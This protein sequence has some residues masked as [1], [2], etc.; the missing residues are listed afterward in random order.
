MYRGG[1]IHSLVSN[2]A[3]RVAARSTLV[4]LLLAVLL[5][6]AA[7]AAAQG[8]ATTH[9]VAW[10]ETL[11]AI[12]VRY[13]VTTD[14]IM[15]AN[16][17]EAADRIFAGQRLVIPGAGGQATSGAGQTAGQHTVQAGE[18]LFRIGLRYGLSVDELVAANGLADAAQVYAGQTL[19]IPTPGTVSVPS[20]GAPSAGPAVRSHTIQRG[21]TLS[22]ISR[23]YNVSVQDIVNANN[24]VNPSAIFAG[25]TLNI[26][27]AASSGGA[28]GYTPSQAA[29]TY[30]VQRGDSLFSIATRFGV[31]V[32]AITQ[33]NNISNPSL[34]HAGNTLTI[35]APGALTQQAAPQ[36]SAPG[37]AKSIVVDV[38][39]QRAYVYENG[40]LKWTFIISTGMPGTP[41]AR[42]NFQVQNKIPNAYAS[43]WDLQ[44]PWW[45][46]IYWAG[47][48]QNGFHALPIMS[49][50]VRLWAGLLGS[51][52]SYGCIILSEYDAKTLYDWADIG[53]PVTIRD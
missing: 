18:N 10:G 13:G 52:A 50:G 5:L 34:V 33:A 45:L 35:P 28:T 41:T 15:Q 43:T 30:T 6:S 29:T 1:W 42:G 31:S 11:S 27:G 20:Q 21:E 51:P 8:E 44:M 26:P 16:N 24:L 19:T 53:T 23:Q 2:S 40:A 32:A 22:A 12:A 4:M 9:V 7:P 38:S 48:L 25:Q 37:A 3:G 47:P 36:A 46:G 14:A 17:L 39:E 49:N